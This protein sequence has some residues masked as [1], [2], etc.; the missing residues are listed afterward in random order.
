MYLARYETAAGPRWA[1]DYMFSIEP[2][3]G[4]QDRPRMTSLLPYLF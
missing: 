2:L 3:A 4:N 1:P